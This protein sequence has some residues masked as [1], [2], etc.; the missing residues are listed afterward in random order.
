MKKNIFQSRAALDCW[1]EQQI[2]LNFYDLRKRIWIISLIPF[3]I[4]ATRHWNNLARKM[5]NNW[6]TSFKDDVK[7]E[8]C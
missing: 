6:I 3:L 5:K 4:A 1:W 7:I 8:F 2:E